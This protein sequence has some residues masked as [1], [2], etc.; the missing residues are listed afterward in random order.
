MAEL[1]DAHDLGSCAVRCESS[2]LSSPK[3]VLVE[4]LVNGGF[5][6]L[7][8]ENK[9]VLAA[10]VALG[11]RILLDPTKT[12][13]RKGI[14][15]ARDFSIIPPLS[16]ER[17]EP[18]CRHFGVCGGCAFQHLQYKA[19]LAAKSAILGE[20]FTG[21][22]TLDQS[23]G[24]EENPLYYRNKAELAFGHDDSEELNLG[25][26]PPGQFFRVLDLA[27]CH[28]FPPWIWN[29]FGRIG[30]LA[31][32]TGLGAFRE[33]DSSGFF[34]LLTA[35]WNESELVLLFRVA[36]PTHPAFREFLQT[37]RAEFSRIIGIKL[38]KPGRGESKL[39]WGREQLLY[40]FGD[41]RLVCGIENF[42]QVN[43]FMFEKLLT[44]L[45][46]EI[47]K[48]DCTRLID[49]FSGVGTIGLY[50]AK[51]L[52]Q[53][54]ELLALETD[55][56]A[57]ALSTFN[58]ELNEVKTYRSE[59]RDL[60]RKGWGASFAVGASSGQKTALVVDPPRAGLSTRTIGELLLIAPEFLFYVSC[61][62]STQRRDLDLI[63]AEGRYELTQLVLFDLFPRT[64]HFESVA[65]LKR[66]S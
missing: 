35:R 54:S 46:L 17:Q 65:V 24:A 22:A 59:V 28:L 1:V 7:R 26:H 56:K 55:S 49:L 23:I 60:Y 34:A 58:A 11:E 19:E 20:I 33:A 16:A 15:W 10:G 51:H 48:T 30:A 41:L 64:Q 18:V 3:E 21:T 31:R 37:L 61:N 29:I 57:V 38:A 45:L 63:L 9:T 6:L 62:A 40:R 4:K 25:F 27:E 14:H 39:H 52:P 32:Q 12:V 42:F 5:G 36:E 50:L 66:I 44:F 47:R 2:S 8:L 43:C 53:I 13:K